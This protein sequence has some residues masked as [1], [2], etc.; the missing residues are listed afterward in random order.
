MRHSWLIAITADRNSI[1][2]HV[3]ADRRVTI[4]S[5]S[6]GRTVVVATTPDVVVREH[7]NVLTVEPVSDV[8]IA[9]VD[10]ITGRT[11]ANRTLFSVPEVY[12]TDFEDNLLISG[13]LADLLPYVGS[14]GLLERSIVDHHVFRWSAGTRT[15][16]EGVFHLLP[17]HELQWAGS[18]SAK[19][20]QLQSLPD[21]VSGERRPVNRESAAIQ[22]E[23][24]RQ[25]VARRLKHT[26][27]ED[28]A[29]LLSGGIDSSVIQMVIESLDKGSTLQT[30][31]FIL[32]TPDWLGEE[33][34]CRE[35]VRIFGTQHEYTRISPSDYPALLVDSISMLGRPFGHDSQPAYIGLFRSLGASG[36]TTLWSGEAADAIFGRT[37]S[38]PRYGYLPLP[39]LWALAI[40]LRPVS[41]NKARGAQSTFRKMRALHDETNPDHLTNTQ[42]R[43]CDLDTVTRWFGER[44]VQE[45]MADRRNLAAQLAVPSSEIERVHMVS[46]FTSALYC[47]SMDFQF[48]A[49]VGCT[50]LNPY[51]DE[52]VI[53]AVLRI[54]PEQ[55]YFHEGR[56]KPLLKLALQ[57]R[58]GPDFVA[59]SKRGGEIYNDLCGWMRDGVLADLV[60]SIERPGYVD[61]KSFQQKIEVPDWTT[62]DLLLM[63]LYKKHLRSFAPAQTKFGLAA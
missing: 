33:E 57:E 48:A 38:K 60:R 50:V 4:H 37:S 55:R 32:D 43:F 11:R 46:L 41:P 61:L 29:V 44:A 39:L 21:F 28:R 47:A 26:R 16:L 18:S 34:Y 53:R 24:L 13:S 63:D 20:R 56:T 3:A 22:I 35:A 58:A 30:R 6:D 23:A 12:W 19:V 5:L 14:R 51:L 1:R 8:T 52:E 36:P 49:A 42:A 15:Y 62:W 40:A 54:D 9:S 17:G 59:R 27:S 2:Q 10:I 25:A 31:S 7:D 45:A